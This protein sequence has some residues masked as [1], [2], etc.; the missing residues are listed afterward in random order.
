MS[1]DAGA[2]VSWPSHGRS[3]RH[4]WWTYLE[5]G[6]LEPFRDVLRETP[7]VV[8]AS[9]DGD[10]RTMLMYAVGS[11]S[12]LV[13]MLIAAGA[14]VNR[15][16]SHG[17]PVWDF[18]PSPAPQWVDVW[19]LLI[20]AGLD[21]NARGP[22][23]ETSLISVCA[24]YF[25]PATDRAHRQSRVSI[26]QLLLRAGA[27]VNAADE[28]GV[29][30]LQAA[31]GSGNTDLAKLLL[32]AG[33]RANAGGRQTRSA[34]FEAALHGHARIV[35]ALLDAGADV[36]AATVGSRM[37]AFPLSTFGLVDADGVTPLIVAAENGH[38]DVV[39]LLA[40]A[41]ADVNR[42]DAIGFTALMGAARAGHA[43]MVRF[44]LERGARP[45][46]A[47]A[48]GKTARAHAVE[49]QHQREVVPVLDRARSAGGGA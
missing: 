16:D 39:R 15:R 26:V 33:A 11:S 46:A 3:G 42:A 1:G 9:V 13:D 32:D 44:L 38:L 12:A 29:T 24:V 27:E 37:R 20:A 47:D 5:R 40:D 8:D 14:D 18:V 36:D 7:A 35:Q 31:A 49:F 2:E 43:G 19:R 17:R 30:P 6:Y 28:Y 25:H 41:G 4:D 48:S 23:K 21:V 10:G 45:G 22:R 34:L